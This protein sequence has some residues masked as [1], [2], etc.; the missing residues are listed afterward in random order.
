MLGPL[1]ISRWCGGR[2]LY[3]RGL[4]LLLKQFCSD[5]DCVIAMASGDCS[6]AQRKPTTDRSNDF[7]QL[8][9]ILNGDSVQ[10]KTLK[11]HG[12]NGCSPLFRIGFSL[13]ARV[14]VVLPFGALVF[15]FVTAIIFQFEEVNKTV[16]NVRVMSPVVSMF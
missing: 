11:G 2:W 15:C 10:T 6:I 9:T 8:P 1:N 14:T 7:A 16:C 5:C 13:L 12:G 3:L 4:N